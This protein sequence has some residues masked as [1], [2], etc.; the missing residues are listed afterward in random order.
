MRTLNPLFA[1]AWFAIAV[2]ATLGA[3][4]TQA[5]SSGPVDA[6]TSIYPARPG[7]LLPSDLAFGV[8]SGTS[9]GGREQIGISDEELATYLQPPTRAKAGRTR[10]PRERPPA[11]ARPE[12]LPALPPLSAAVAHVPERA[13][14]TELQA[15]AAPVE[16]RAADPDA[17]RYAQREQRASALSDYRGGDAIVISVTTLVIIA[18]IVLLVILVT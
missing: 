8:G 14:R 9:S 7:T 3:C 15:Q 13:A 12:P 11:P 17:A 2:I 1:T 10:T 5:T 18:L 6:R 4:G 16:P